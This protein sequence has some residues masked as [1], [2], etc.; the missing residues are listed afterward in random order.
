[1]S[2][3]VSGLDLSIILVNWNSV[4]FLKACLQS[5]FE[6]TK[7]VSYEVIVVDNASPDGCGEMLR[8]DFPSVLFVQS[9]RNLGFAG[10]NNLG[11]Q[12]SSSRN[13]LF[14]NPDTE[15]IGD[16]IERLVHALETA[17]KAGIV[18]PRL[19]N[20]DLTVQTSCIR[21]FPN[22][23]NEVLDSEFLREK[24]PKSRLWG[25]AP[26]LEAPT[27][28][29]PVD[30]VSG[31]SLMV[32]RDAFE[33]AGLF[34]TAYFMYSEDVDLSYLVRQAG[35]TNYYVPNAVVLHHGGQSSSSRDDRNFA[36]VVMRESRYRFFRRRR[37]VLYAF[38]YKLATAISAAVR[39]AV[40]VPFWT[41]SGA[42][43]RNSVYR[44]F[45]KWVRILRWSVGLE[46]WAQR[47]H[48]QTGADE[49]S[50]GLAPA[51]VGNK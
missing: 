41:V 8:Q 36:D 49:A 17:P 44:S 4:A 16:A 13:L 38:A 22:L 33:A 28:P 43:R 47:L 3:A 20:T 30:A 23:L 18:A 29:V 45:W 7:G 31:A 2:P 32:R 40:L 19:L 27:A 25:M 39:V 50:G 21:S 12:H 10:A 26:L 9:P 14:L 1:M 46:G 6:K 42:V 51:P 37:G 24:F 15:V 34:S 5:V 48:Q 35:W 11:F